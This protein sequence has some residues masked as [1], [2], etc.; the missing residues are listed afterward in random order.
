MQ[1]FPPLGMG[2]LLF[3][4]LIP[5]LSFPCSQYPHILKP[6]PQFQRPLHIEVSLYLNTA[7]LMYDT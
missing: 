1:A 5:F 4:L 6:F 3:L 7:S 2:Q